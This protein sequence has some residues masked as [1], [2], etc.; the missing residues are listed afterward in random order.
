M[1]ET[2]IVGGGLAGASLA[3][4]LARRGVATA[5]I[6]RQSPEQLAAEETDGRTTALAA[7]P[8]GL[9]EDIG[10]WD[11]LAPHAGAITDIRVSDRGS[12]MKLHF[13]HRD[14]GGEPMGHIVENFRLRRALLDRVAQ[15]PL[16]QGYWECAL[17]GY[18]AD[19]SQ[20]RLTLDGSQVIEARLAIA[21]DGRGSALRRFA[22][23]GV[24]AIDY[25][26]TAIVCAVAHEHPHEGIAHE[27]FLDGGPF[28][29]L[30]MTDGTTGEH[31][32]SV[33]WTERRPL[34]EHL[35]TL[36][37]AA[38]E[39]ELTRRFG[40][41]LGGL[42]IQG[43]TWSY[44]LSVTAAKRL[45]GPRLALVGEAAHGMHPIA[46]QGFNVSVRDIECLSDAIGK[47]LS[48]GQDPGASPLLHAYA[49][50]RW[51]DIAAMLA[52]T[53]GLNRLFMTNLPPLALGRRLGI[54]AV[55]RI[56]P[57]KRRFQRHA[58]GLGLFGK[59]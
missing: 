3:L 41:F 21:A 1:L 57:L 22:D 27:R 16:I 54:S 31:R 32:S 39:R 59:A 35:L 43:G 37:K 28:A 52:A 49:K 17:T 12:T 7:G 53:D 38:L 6:E 42:S 18:E 26:Q 33:V 40:D 48:L 15:E 34:A 44:P 45:T 46:G 9:M 47:A 29:I 19:T 4:A 14:V 58:M 25:K 51:P 13:D 24:R 2:A 55:D 30:P 5:L 36:E 10:V 23:I 56:P 50:R 8:R 20:V 11:M